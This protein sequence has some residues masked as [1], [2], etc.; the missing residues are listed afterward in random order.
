V[1]PVHCF[2]ASV[3]DRLDR[4]I[5]E[6]MPELSRS[7]VRR[8]IEE[9]RVAV[10]GAV[11]I[12]P[13]MAVAAGAAVRVE[14]PVLADLELAADEVPLD[15]I[16]EDEE[17]LVLNKQPGLVVHPREGV[18]EVTLINAVRARYP[19]VREIDASNRGGIVHRLDRDTSGVIALAKSEASQFALKEQWRSRETLKIYLALVEG[20]VDLPEG[21]I[22]A[23][24][25]P[26]P[27]DPRRR[28]VVE[29]GQYARSQY[30]VLE[31]YGDEAALL[32]VRIFTGRTH[33]IRVHLLA[34]GHP[35]IGDLMYGHPSD[36]I[37]RQALHAWKLG[38]TLASNGAWRE[39]TAPVP[40]D[41]RA[42]ID[43]LRN[44]H[45]VPASE[46]GAAS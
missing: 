38:F 26:N 18:H 19:E 30:R 34:I 28:A 45:H 37:D 17:T 42:A 7:Q 22:E 31:Q 5:V 14:E 25:G 10:D 39:F 15:V 2:V 9:G 13:A 4:A 21:I 8:L 29:E 43:S 20:V 12:K 32:E 24:L 11:V 3:P 23:P 6:A 27:D 36:L 46:I 40:E 16:Y 33:Q 44:R 35:I 1:T 41:M